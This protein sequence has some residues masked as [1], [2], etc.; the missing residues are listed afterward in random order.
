[1]MENLHRDE[2]TMPTVKRLFGG[3]RDY[4]AAAR[5]T[6]MSGRPT[7]GRARQRV[8]AAIGH[9]LAF[10]SWRSLTREQQLDDPQAAKL[11]CRLVA[12]AAHDPDTRRRVPPHGNRPAVGCP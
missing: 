10:A 8:R 12:A 7:R 5:E 9:T 11:M 2:A 3:F 1:M 6:L 4:I